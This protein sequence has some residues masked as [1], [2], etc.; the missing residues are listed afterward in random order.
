LT[1]KLFVPVVSSLFHVQTS[2]RKMMVEFTHDIDVITRHAYAEDLWICESAWAS[3]GVEETMPSH[4]R[5]E[6]LINSLMHDKHGSP[7][8][9]GFFSF[10][11]KAPSAVRN[12]HVRHRIGSYSSASSRY[13]EIP[14][15]YYIP[16]RPLK[17]VKGSKQMK[18]EFEWHEN[19]ERYIDQSKLFYEFL[20]TF[21]EDAKAEGF[22]STEAIRWFN[23]DSLVIPYIARFNPR[24]LMHFLS[25]RTHDKSANHVS[26]PMWEIEQVALQI[27]R[28]FAK[29]LPITYAAW[30]EFGR[31]AP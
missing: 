26:Y 9:E 4:E 14:R 2:P 10:W 19:H 11:I 30:N 12:E 24:N 28:T 21:I 3:S 18:P 27:E 16:N 8:E 25:L 17:R 7:F 1:T 31:E 5:I 22:R 29:A 6:G 20:D 15:L 23:T 13:M